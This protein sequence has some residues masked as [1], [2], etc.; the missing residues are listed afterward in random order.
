[1]TV[2]V[3]TKRGLDDGYDVR[4]GG[5]GRLLGGVYYRPGWRHWKAW[6]AIECTDVREAYTKAGAVEGLMEHRGIEHR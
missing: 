2:V 3:A 1:M 4:D 5:S 6:C